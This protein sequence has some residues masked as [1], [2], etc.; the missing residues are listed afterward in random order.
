MATNDKQDNGFLPSI[1]RNI[2]RV[3]PVPLDKSEIEMT[4]NSEKEADGPL[5]KIETTRGA[6]TVKPPT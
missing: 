1:N 3:N 2:I 6:D 4:E 5:Q